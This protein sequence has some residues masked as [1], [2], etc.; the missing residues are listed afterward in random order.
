[1]C[2]WEKRCCGI[3][4]FSTCMAGWLVTFA[5]WQAV[6]SLHHSLMS[7][8]NPGQTKWLLTNLVVARVPAWERWCTCL[9]TALRWLPGI[10]GIL[11]WV[12]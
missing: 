12:S 7:A 2:M 8:A 5:L 1:M 3:S 11:K 9:K 10:S 6:H 4:I